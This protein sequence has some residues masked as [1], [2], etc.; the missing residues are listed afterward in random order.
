[1]WWSARENVPGYREHDG[2]KKKNIMLFNTEKP[3]SIYICFLLIEWPITEA[4]HTEATHNINNK[5]ISS[6]IAATSLI[7]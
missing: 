6:Y 7:I 5:K 3:W 2:T 4:R 1:M